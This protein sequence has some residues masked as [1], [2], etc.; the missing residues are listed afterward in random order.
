MADDLTPPKAPE[1]PALALTRRQLVTLAAGAVLTL[2]VLAAVLVIA[3]YVHQRRSLTAFPTFAPANAGA[4]TLPANAVSF[5]TYA[6]RAT[7]TPMPT[8]TAFAYKGATGAPPASSGYSQ[9]SPQSGLSANCRAQ[10]DYAASV[11]ASN[12]AYDKSSYQPLIDYYNSLLTQ[13]E[14]TRDASLLVQ[15]QA[16]LKQV[17]SELQSALSAENTRYKAEIAAIKASC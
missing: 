1:R 9:S 3:L 17:K 8:A 5:P 11:H 7:I 13:A 10:L 14:Q 2:V 4:P 6:Y 12:V 16:G 15:A